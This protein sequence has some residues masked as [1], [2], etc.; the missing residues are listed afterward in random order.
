M[1]IR[2]M[3]GGLLYTT[4]LAGN[5]TG[6]LS[7]FELIETQTVGAGGAA[8]ITFS[9]IPQTYKHL[10]IRAI[11]RYT[12]AGNSTTI[13][14]NS[15]SAAN[16]S[17]HALY[18]TGAVAGSSSGVNQTFG[19]IEAAAIGHDTTYMFASITDILDYANTSKNKT[20]RALSGID[21]NSNASEIDLL[22]T[23]WR[24]TSAINSITL[25]IN[26]SQSFAQY[27]TFSLYGIK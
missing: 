3:S 10:Q 20:V 4:M 17:W 19:L 9:S 1:S 21:T 24:S 14:F 8:S 6:S 12:V 25:G 15:D 22:S 26:G 13:R 23:N 18:G 7:A 27:S 11:T 5:P 2:K 16:Y